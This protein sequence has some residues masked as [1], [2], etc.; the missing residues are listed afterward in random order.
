MNLNFQKDCI[1]ELQE[2][3]NSDRHSIL[4]EG[5]AGCGK[6]YLAKSYSKMLGIH[7]FVSVNP[8]VQ[9]I[10]EAMDNSY[11]LTSPVCFCIENLD[12]GVAAASYTLLKFL[13]EPTKQ[14]Y[15]VVTCTNRY[16]LPDTIMSRSAC[17]TL[18]YPTENDINEYA[19]VKDA[20][21]YEDMHHR[22]IWKAVRSLKMAD[23]VYQFNQDQLDYFKD[24]KEACLFKDTVANLAWKFG[25]FNDGSECDTNLVMN[26][27]Y[28]ICNSD[29]VRRYVIDCVKDLSLSRLSSHAVLAKF[30]F[31][32]KYGD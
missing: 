6:S 13:E 21:R 17:V 3:A 10:R 23:T 24:L 14:V 19:Q 15:I 5:P 22:D 12:S 9:A 27:I 29:R 8:T 2:L 18:A 4:I 30:V 20:R 28:Q 32:C 25:H 26:Y 7:D 11:N 16:K 31:E 1:E